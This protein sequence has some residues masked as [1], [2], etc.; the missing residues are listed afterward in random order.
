MVWTLRKN[1]VL[2]PKQFGACLGF[3]GAMSL[4]IGVVWASV[5]AWL[6][7]FFVIV[8]CLVLLVAFF[9]YSAHATDF[10]RV[11]LT[12]SEILFE[13]ETGGKTEVDSLP[14]YQVKARMIELKGKRLVEFKWGLRVIRV[15]RLVDLKS[16]E[17]FFGE[18]KGYIC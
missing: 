14:R 11:V 5:G 8:E 18:I 1:C 15:G 17:K 7:F 4:S 9:C 16:R 10:E 12:D 13:F 3:A 6:I 2:S